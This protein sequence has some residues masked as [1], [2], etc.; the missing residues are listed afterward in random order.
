[1]TWCSIPRNGRQPGSWP[2]A[3]AAGNAPPLGQMVRLIAGFGGFLRAQTTV[4]GPKA[5]WEGMQSLSLAIAFEATVQCM[6]GMDELWV[7][8]WF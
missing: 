4:I 6:R 5:I 8:G 2:I 3:A 1:M 7:I